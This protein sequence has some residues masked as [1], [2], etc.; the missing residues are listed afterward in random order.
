[1]ASKSINKTNLCQL[2]NISDDITK[3]KVALEY[4]DNAI[5]YAELQTITNKRAELLCKKYHVKPGD[6]IGI[7]VDCKFESII[8]I[9]AILKV[10]GTYIVLDNKWPQARIEQAIRLASLNIL[11]SDKEITEILHNE[12][13]M[14]FIDSNEDCGAYSGVFLLPSKKKDDLAYIVF[15][16]G[17]TGVP[18]GVK[19][20]QSALLHYLDWETSQK[21]NKLSNEYPETLTQII[22][23]GEKL[24]VTSNIKNLFANMLHCKLINLYGASE[25]QVISIYQMQGHPSLWPDVPPIGQQIKHVSIYLLDENKKNINGSD[26]G[27]IHIDSKCV[28]LGYLTDDTSIMKKKFISVK[29]NGIFKKLY[30]T[31][32]LGRR[33]PD[34]NIEYI[35]RSDFQIKIRGHRV[36]LGEIDQTLVSHPL[37]RQSVT[38]CIDNH[39]NFNKLVSYV[40][41]EYYR[42]ATNR[43][44]IISDL[45]DGFEFTLEQ[46]NK[47][48]CS[49]ESTQIKYTGQS[50]AKDIKEL[51]KEEAKNYL[52]NKLPD[53]MIPSDI[54]M[55][56]KLPLTSNGKVDRKALFLSEKKFKKY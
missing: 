29:V 54:V 30:N 22:S 44:N 25:I 12:S 4:S 10:G 45:S 47:R 38:L 20:S 2:L 14:L 6:L 53:Y 28:T 39:A 16:S 9:I 1:M 19:M 40:V 55:L 48:K 17:S 21:N 24:V 27:E 52:R 33:L 15:T 18:K 51:I 23:S 3:R 49:L 8:W 43:T 35:G 41:P 11:I 42:R 46:H 13:N 32:D 50:E 7:Y 37:I 34:G 5:S 36:E 26:I 56:D 31:G